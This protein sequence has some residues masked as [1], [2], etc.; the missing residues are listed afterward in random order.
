[1]SAT[2]SSSARG[3]RRW[4]WP[5]RSRPVSRELLR[6][7]RRAG[8]RRARLRHRVA[9]R[10]WTRSSAPATRGSRP[11]RR[12]SSRDC[13]IDLH[14]GPERDRRLLRPR[15]AGLD[16]RGPDRAG[17]ARPGRARDPRDDEAGAGRGGGRARS[18]ADAGRRARRA[19]RSRANGAIVVARSRREAIDRS[20]IASRPSTW[21]START[22][23]TP[24]TCRRHDLRGPVERA[25]RRRLRHRVESRAADGR[26]GAVPRRPERRGLRARLLGADADARRGIRRHRPGR[27][28]AGRGRGPDAHAPIA[29]GSRS[30]LMTYGPARRARRERAC[31]C[32]ST[33][34][35]PAV[36]RRCS[37]A[38]RRSTRDR[39]SRSIPDYDGVTARVAAWFGVDPGRVAADQRPRRGPAWS[40]RVAALRHARRGCPR[41]AIVVVRT[42]VRDVRVCAERVSAPAVV[43]HP[44]GPD[45]RFRSTR[46]SPRFRR[47]T[48]DLPDRSEQS[49]GLGIPRAGSS[50]SP[51]AA[52]QAIVLV[53]EAYADFSGRTLIGPR[54]RSLP[55]LVVGR[56]FAKAHGLAALRVGALVGASR[57]ARPSAAHA[58]RR[59]ASTSARCAALDAALDDEAYF[60]WYV[61]QSARVDATLIYDV[62][63]QA[64]PALLAERGNF[65]LV[66]VGDRAPA[67][68]AARWRPA[69]SSSATSR[70]AGCAGLPPH[71]RRRR[72]PHRGVRW[73]P[74][75]TSL[76][77]GAIDRQT[78]ET[79]YPARLTLDGRGRYD[80]GP[81]S[82]SSTTCSSCS[83]AWRL[84][85]DARADGRPR[86]RRAPHRRGRRHRARRGRRRGRSAPSAASTAPA[87]S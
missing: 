31:A 19:R 63:R 69:A 30:R 55:N 17:R 20:S 38:L 14:A 50:A 77:R 47:D 73:P 36:R 71:H 60:E 4:C 66:R 35:P 42:G 87:T 79:R 22:T 41:R 25:G 39:T 3:R 1:M 84:R 51:R 56:T 78:T 59:S 49:D 72:R 45:F 48:R 46:C 43:R 26:R 40:S 21:S 58:C 16:R 85:P 53:D 80:V 8:D 24:F 74:W 86:R 44:A 81:A 33:R 32:T 2:S 83:A 67:R 76:R 11:P 29:S 15:P 28:R 10:A 52:P 6:H 64:R 27:R 34:T 65:V 7:R 54:A 57:D 9:A 18:R 70:R 61:A 12:S 23:S 62:L 75:R 68:V 5:P 37:A 13:P 82:G